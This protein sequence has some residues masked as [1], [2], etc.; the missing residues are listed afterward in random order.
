MLFR[1]KILRYF[2]PVY[3]IILAISTIFLP[4]ESILWLPVVLLQMVF[5]FTAILGWIFEKIGITSTVL[6]ISFFVLT[7]NIGFLL[8]IIRFVS[9][10][11]NSIWDHSALN[12]HKN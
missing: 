5:Y 10:K 6:K 11:P 12:E 9:Q 8:G 2:S 4:M 3:L 1:S 7:M